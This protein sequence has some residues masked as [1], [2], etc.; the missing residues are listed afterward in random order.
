M[1]K[2]HKIFLFMSTCL[3]LLSILRIF[4]EGQNKALPQTSRYKRQI[5][6]SYWLYSSCRRPAWVHHNCQLGARGIGS[7]VWH[8]I[9]LHTSLDSCLNG[10]HNLLLYTYDYS[11]DDEYC[12]IS[13]VFVVLCFRHT[14]CIP[15]VPIVELKP[16]FWFQS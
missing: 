9:V 4:S 16:C 5:L 10:N 12:I 8:L 6:K 15:T 1:K 3:L 7:Q 11:M 2:M 14:N 13:S